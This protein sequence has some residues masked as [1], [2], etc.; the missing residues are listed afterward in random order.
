MKDLRNCSS[1]E[2]NY[3]WKTIPD[4]DRAKCITYMRI[5]Y[6]DNRNNAHITLSMKIEEEISFP[7]IN[8]VDVI[9]TNILTAI[10][11]GR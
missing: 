4:I 6:I 3:N 5:A 8:I 11:N 9:P 1:R 10:R 2:T 7:A